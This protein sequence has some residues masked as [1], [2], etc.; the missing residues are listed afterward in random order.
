MKNNKTNTQKR[1]DQSMLVTKD[2]MDLVKFAQKAFELSRPQGMGFLHAKAG[3][4]LSEDEAK[5]FIRSEQGKDTLSMDYVKGRALK[6]H[7]RQ[8]DN[9]D[10]QLS[11]SW[12]DHTDEQYKDLLLSVGISRHTIGDHGCACNCDGCRENR[13]LPPYTKEQAEKDIAEGIKCNYIRVP[14]ARD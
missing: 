2:K 4:T 3:D 8:Q 14:S 9:G 12:Y 7:V 1:K 10:F 11:D 13:G 6:L 5:Q